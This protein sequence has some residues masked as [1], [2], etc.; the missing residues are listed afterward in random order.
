MS[1]VRTLTILAAGVAMISTILYLA[2]GTDTSNTAGIALGLFLGAIV[3]WSG[4]NWPV[5]TSNE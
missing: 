3:V 2:F 1:S 5:E 4:E